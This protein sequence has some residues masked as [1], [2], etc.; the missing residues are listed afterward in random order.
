MRVCPSVTLRR[1]CDLFKLSRNRS[2]PLFCLPGHPNLVDG[3]AVGENGSAMD[4]GLTMMDLMF[5]AVMCSGET[6]PGVFTAV[7]T[8]SDLSSSLYT[9]DSADDIDVRAD[10]TGTDWLCCSC[11]LWFRL[12]LV[13]PDGHSGIWKRSSSSKL[14]D[15]EATD[16]SEP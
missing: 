4:S 14:S 13:R 10:W 1:F 16:A 12:G 9:V 5:S 3:R 15:S 2:W 7:L 6:P 8:P 11:F